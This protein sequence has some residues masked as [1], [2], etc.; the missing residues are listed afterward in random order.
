VRC[1]VSHFA[2]LGTQLWLSQLLLW[3]AWVSVELM[4][5]LCMVEYQMMK[6]LLWCIKL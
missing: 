5:M 2:G 6:Q 3:V 4:L 1:D